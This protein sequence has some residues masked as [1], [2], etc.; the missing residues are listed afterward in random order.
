MFCLEYFDGFLRGFLF[1]LFSASRS[2]SLLSLMSCSA[3]LSRELSSSPLCSGS[4]SVLRVRPPCPLL[5][6]N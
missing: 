6:R 1:V 3:E 5:E 2:L 4:E